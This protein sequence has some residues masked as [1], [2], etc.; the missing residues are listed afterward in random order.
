MPYI[1]GEPLNLK[2]TPDKDGDG[3]GWLEWDEEVVRKGFR[4]KRVHRKIRKDSMPTTPVCADCGVAGHTPGEMV[5]SSPQDHNEA[6]IEDPM[7]TER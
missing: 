1:K 2:F 3:G 4:N 7:E 5:C 6:G